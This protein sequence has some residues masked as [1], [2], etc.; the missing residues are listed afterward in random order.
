MSDMNQ[1]PPSGWQPTQPTP[2]AGAPQPT[3]PT[4]P[5]QPAPSGWPAPHGP[6]WWQAS[7]GRWYPPAGQPFGPPVPAPGPG[8][9]PPPA[10]K[11]NKGCL[12]AAVIVGGLLVFGAVAA[13]V[14][15]AVF[16]NR[17]DDAVEDAIEGNPDELDDAELVACETDESGFM[18]A[19]VRVTNDSPERSSYL[20]DVEFESA[21]GDEQFSTAIAT[22][23]GIDPDQS[24][25]VEAN[26]FEE[27]LEDDFDCRIQ[28]VNRFS[29]E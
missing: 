17:V 1:Q 22:P 10:P 11:S 26:S 19:T 2:P 25:E 21:D 5:T 12:W 7:D 3:Q 13:F 4:Q 14:V 6:G 29:D 16:V 24:T 15:I 8:G 27:P 20:I 28:G 18:V 23:S 9:P